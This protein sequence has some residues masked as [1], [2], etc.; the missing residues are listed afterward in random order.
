LRDSLDLLHYLR[1]LQLECRHLGW[2]LAAD[3]GI[4]LRVPNVALPLVAQ[5][6]AHE[7][8]RRPG[9]PLLRFLRGILEAQGKKT[10]NTRKV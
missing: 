4:T 6:V 7:G 8:T 9:G 1:L 2:V 10:K 3:V 5:P